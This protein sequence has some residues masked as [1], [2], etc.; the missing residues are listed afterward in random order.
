MPNAVATKPKTRRRKSDANGNQSA[1][2]LSWNAESRPIQPSYNDFT[3]RPDPYEEWMTD[4]KNRIAALYD[5]EG[6]GVKHQVALMYHYAGERAMAVALGSQNGIPDFVYPSMRVVYDKMN[7]QG[8]LTEEQLDRYPHD[9]K[10]FYSQMSL[11]DLEAILPEEYLTY[12]TLV[13]D[14]RE[15]MSNMLRWMARGLYPNIA[16]QLGKR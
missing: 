12:G 4:Y 1:P 11:D 13:L 7:Q 15:K 16:Y 10:D 3:V 9:P 2:F 8:M 5:A 6:V 14:D